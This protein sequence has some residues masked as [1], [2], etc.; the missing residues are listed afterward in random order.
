[1]VPVEGAVI[2]GMINDRAGVLYKASGIK[3]RE[4]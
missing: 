4:W 1:M 3:R 2:E